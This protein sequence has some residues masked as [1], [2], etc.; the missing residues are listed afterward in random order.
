MSGSTHMNSI[1]VQIR[2]RLVSTRTA[3]VGEPEIVVGAEIENLA[4]RTRISAI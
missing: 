1:L 2:D 4:L 3:L